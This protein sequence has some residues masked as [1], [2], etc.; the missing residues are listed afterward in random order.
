MSQTLGLIQEGIVE[1]KPFINLLLEFNLLEPFSANLTLKNNQQ[2]L[3][4][5]FYTINEEKLA[6][7]P[8]DAIKK[9]HD[10]G[11]LFDIYMQM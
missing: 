7:L 4:Q 10:S 11:F 3:L 5:G 2:Y 9:L 6:S 1:V 8:T